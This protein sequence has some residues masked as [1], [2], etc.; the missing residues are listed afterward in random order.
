MEAALDE[1]REDDHAG[2]PPAAVC[3]M[4]TV[5]ANR[6]CT[7]AKYIR[8]L[9]RE[10]AS[11]MRLINASH[12][13]LQTV[14]KLNPSPAPPVR[15]RLEYTGEKQGILERAFAQTETVPV[16][17]PQVVANAQETTPVAYDRSQPGAAGGLFGE[18]DPI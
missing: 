12:R 18:L 7:D 15:P 14:R 11:L 13:E 8:Q 4:Q 17:E 1:A 3:E 10:E 6:T 5:V 9:Q 16:P 2:L